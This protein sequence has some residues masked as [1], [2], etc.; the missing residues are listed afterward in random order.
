MKAQQVGVC[1]RLDLNDI[2]AH[3][4]SAGN[5]VSIIKASLDNGYHDDREPVPNAERNDGENG[6]AQ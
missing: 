6:T 5:W 2:S 1:G 3:A 4:P